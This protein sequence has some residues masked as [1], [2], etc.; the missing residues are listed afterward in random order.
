[1]LGLPTYNT[2]NL[3][4]KPGIT[5]LSYWRGFC[6]FNMPASSDNSIVSREMK[7]TEHAAFGWVLHDVGLV[8]DVVHVRT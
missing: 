3:K 7:I 5:S 6:C 1:M 8:A 2:T 4:S